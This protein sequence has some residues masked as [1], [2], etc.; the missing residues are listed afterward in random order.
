MRRMRSALFVVPVAAMVLAGCGEDEGSGAEGKDPASAKQGPMQPLSKAQLEKALVSGGDV[1]GV[2]LREPEAAE[3]EISEGQVAS[4]AACQPLSTM[5][6]STAKA[7]ANERVAMSYHAESVDGR[8]WLYAHDLPGAKKVMSELRAAVEACSGG[9]KTTDEVL[10]DEF[11]STYASVKG[12]EAPQLGA[13]AVAYELEA[14]MGGTS[15]PMH[16]TVVRVGT[17]IA[18]FQG[19]NAA[20]PA[21]GSVPDEV[22]KAQAEK[23][24]DA[25]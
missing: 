18:A 23:L 10:V 21:Q 4:E 8:L 15:M 1:D 19:F 17:A 25:G 5:A 20:E 11:G 6:G 7:T 3:L 22:V 12:H 9:F 13:E 24:A 16:Y 14:D 2:Q